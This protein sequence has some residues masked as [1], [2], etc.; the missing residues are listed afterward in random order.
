MPTTAVMGRLPQFQP[1][2]LEGQVQP[3][4]G[5]T[6]YLRFGNVPVVV[7]LVVALAA[8]VAAVRRRRSGAARA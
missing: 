3:R 1:S 2:V 5:L 6:P 4:T 7:V 8:V